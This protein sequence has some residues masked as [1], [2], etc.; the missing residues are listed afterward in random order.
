MSDDETPRTPI[1]RAFI[2][3]DPQRTELILVR[4][5]QQ[6]F[7]GPDAAVE[8]WRDPPLT[9]LGE[10]QAAAAGQELSEEAV[11]AVYSS[12]LSRAHRTGEAVAE[13]H[14]LDVTV[15][16]SLAEI[17]MFGDLKPHERPLDVM[18]E[19]ELE[20][21]RR[22]FARERR[23]EVYPYTESSIDFRRR[24]GNVLEGIIAAHPAQK[25]VVACHGGVINA[26]VAD[27]LKVDADMFFRP[28][29]ASIHRVL[30][31]RERRVVQTL[32]EMSHL[33]HPDDLLS[34]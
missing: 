17:H 33:R 19:T 3:N 22:R 34:F 28:A 31:R 26:F 2:T 8:D 13:R 29:H 21:A 1:D 10:K 5:G 16:E 20:G 24:I 27:F 18:S 6:Q 7:P 4:H 30:A 23:W 15:I 32:N 11:A 12:R 25:V 14:G 9:E